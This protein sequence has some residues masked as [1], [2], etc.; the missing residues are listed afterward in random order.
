MNECEMTVDGGVGAVTGISETGH[1]RFRNIWAGHRL[2][3]SKVASTTY[4]GQEPTPRGV[5]A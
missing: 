3:S 4:P 1:G 5:R 2:G